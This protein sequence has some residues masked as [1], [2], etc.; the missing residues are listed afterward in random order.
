MEKKTPTVEEIANSVRKHLPSS[1]KYSV[2]KTNT[3]CY[4]LQGD[5]YGPATPVLSLYD[6]E[7]ILHNK[8]PKEIKSAL[9]KGLKDLGYRLSKQAKIGGGLLFLYR[10]TVSTT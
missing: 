5:W 8:G 9:R 6:G 3:F 7:I 10:N 4:L 1:D 2:I